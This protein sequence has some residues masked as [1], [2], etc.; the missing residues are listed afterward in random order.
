MGTSGP[1]MVLFN[2]GLDSSST[3]WAL[4]ARTAGNKPTAEKRQRD[5][6]TLR[7]G[8]MMLPTTRLSKDA[9]AL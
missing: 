8:S 4:A 2:E 9:I 7:P 3:A 1:A 6:T 5:R